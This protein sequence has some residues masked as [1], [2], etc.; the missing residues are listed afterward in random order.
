M[1][2]EIGQK[3]RVMH[4]GIGRKSPEDI[5]KRGKYGRIHIITDKIITIKTNNYIMS[6][7]IND[8]ISP[9]EHYLLIWSGM[10]WERLKVT[11]DISTFKEFKLLS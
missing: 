3:V 9:Y 6:F 1:H 5:S 7:N 10:E 8:I 4:T 11:Q 2:L